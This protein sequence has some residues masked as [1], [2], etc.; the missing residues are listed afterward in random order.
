MDPRAHRESARTSDPTH[1]ATL[2]ATIRQNLNHNRRQRLHELTTPTN[3]EAAF[4]AAEAE[5][6]LRRFG[7]V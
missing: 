1:L 4:D 3:A 6:E 5:E 7:P 2:V